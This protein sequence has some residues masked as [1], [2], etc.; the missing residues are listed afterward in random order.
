[1]KEGLK[2]L[3][4]NEYPPFTRPASTLP[5]TCRGEGVNSIYSP[6]PSRHVG[7]EWKQRD[8]SFSDF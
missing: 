6:T 4:E 5:P 7:R 2:R 8:G 3:H 1:M